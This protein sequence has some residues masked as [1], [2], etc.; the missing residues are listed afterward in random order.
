[1]WMLLSLVTSLQD[2]TKDDV[3]YDAMRRIYVDGFES[4]QFWMR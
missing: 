2:D 4:N 3:P 1:M